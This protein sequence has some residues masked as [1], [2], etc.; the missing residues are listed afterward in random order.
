MLQSKETV[1]P[2]GFKRDDLDQL[3]SANGSQSHIPSKKRKRGEDEES[4]GPR[5]KPKRGQ[6]FDSESTTTS[7]AVKE[8][9]S[10][11]EAPKPG[12]VIGALIGKKR[13]LRKAKRG[14]G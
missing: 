6:L 7:L 11:S 12:E 1:K 8:S 9:K 4:T 2:H 3:K 5:K 10:E 13:K 14:G